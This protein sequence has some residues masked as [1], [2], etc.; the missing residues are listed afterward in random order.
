[1]NDPDQVRSLPV[2]STV[3]VEDAELATAALGGSQ[4]ACESLVRRFER[5]VYNFVARLVRDPAAAED[6]TQDTFLKVF[7]ALGRYDPRLRFS[8]W[9]FRIAH[10]TAV[11]HLRQ[12]GLLLAD[13][14]PGADGDD[15]DPMARVADPQALSPEEAV[16]RGELAAALD[17]ALD[18]LRPEYR[19]AI[20]LRHQ[21]D[22]DYAE[23][24]EVLDVPLGTVKTYL[25]RARRELAAHLADRGWR[26]A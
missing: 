26:R 4:S 19:A 1:M 18:A 17:E 24:A 11:D 22:L 20:V 6:L 13:P 16:A 5:P 14:A 15:A 2:R 9:L 3:D 25:H 7:R 8:S 23:I 10:N 12:R 21:E